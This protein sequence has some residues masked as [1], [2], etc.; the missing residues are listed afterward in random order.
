[1]TYDFIKWNLHYTLLLLKLQV[2]FRILSVLQ[3]LHYT[4]L[5]LKQN[6]QYKNTSYF[7]W[8]T[9]HSA[10]I[11]TF[12]KKPSIFPKFS[13]TLHSATIFP[14]PL[15]FTLHS[16]TIKTF[17]DYIKSKEKEIFTLHSATIKTNVNK[18]IFSHVP[19]LHYTLL[20]LKLTPAGNLSFVTVKFTLHSAT[21][22]T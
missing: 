9:L 19:D 21:I 13:F 3:D 12:C 15:K 11:K 14:N 8:F 20:L 5:L 7:T 2:L 18:Y 22:K 1:M 17:Y 10:T 4:L 6:L 16:A